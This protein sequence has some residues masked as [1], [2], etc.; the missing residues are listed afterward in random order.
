MI[1]LGL[2]LTVPNW[3]V[4]VHDRLF[5]MGVHSLLLLAAGVLLTGWL[6]FFIQ[7]LACHVRTGSAGPQYFS[8][9]HGFPDFPPRMDRL[10]RLQRHEQALLLWLPMGCFALLTAVGLGLQ[11]IPEV[12]TRGFGT[13]LVLAAQTRWLLGLLPLPDSHFLT[14]LGRLLGKENILVSWQRFYTRTLPL[15]WKMHE[16]LNRHQE[17]SMLLSSIYALV[18][19]VVFLFML[20]FSWTGG[21]AANQFAERHAAF[22]GPAAMFLYRFMQWSTLAIAVLLAL[23]WAK[24]PRGWMGVF[25]RKSPGMVLLAFI[26]LF[27]V[28]AIPFLF[29]P[30]SLHPRVLSFWCLVIPALQ[31]LIPEEGR[32]LRRRWKDMVLPVLIVCT[33]FFWSSQPEERIFPLSALALY[34]LDYIRRPAVLR[35]LLGS[36]RLRG[37]ALCFTLM[38]VFSLAGLGCS[39][40][41]VGLGVVVCI[42]LCAV[43][44][45][46]GIYMR[47]SVPS[48]FFLDPGTASRWIRENEILEAEGS[49][50]HYASVVL[51]KGVEVFF[52]KSVASNLVSKAFRLS[53]HAKVDSSS[54][55]YGKH[56]AG[57]LALKAG[58][59]RLHRVLA[60]T[61]GSW[62]TEINFNEVL[63]QPADQ[64]PWDKRGFLRAF[65]ENRPPL[66]REVDLRAVLKLV[67]NSL[68]FSSFDDTQQQRIARAMVP[69]SFAAGSMVFEQGDDGDRL[70]MIIRGSVQVNFLDQDGDRHPLVF[71]K[72]GDFFG[73]QALLKH[74]PRSASVRVLTESVLVSFSSRAF[75]ELTMA[76]PE[77]LGK[78]IRAVDDLW[79]IKTTPIF[80][81][82]R[83]DSLYPVL[84]AFQHEK[85]QAGQKV[86][87][88]GGKGDK[89]YIIKNGQATVL[90]KGKPIAR[91]ERGD[92]F[93]EI[94]LLRDI[95]RTASIVAETELECL[96]LSGKTFQGI[97]QA[98]P[99]L[100][101]R[102]KNESVHRLAEQV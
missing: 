75:A 8:L 52:G 30:G 22:S 5:S 76:N 32:D 40:A 68:L 90:K 57:I 37:S 11:F 91:L 78:L 87:S 18:C 39:Y 41:G 61:V 71:L 72:R 64:L 7:A 66:E 45:L 13:A 86:F 16:R 15:I 100:Q 26:G 81:S 85:T 38:A 50:F 43:M 4:M 95:P 60:H 28:G 73:E 42:Y 70:Y 98:N 96:V 12:W 93:G 20:R 89:F 58:E 31:F 80:Q 102:L 36:G 74:R 27:L 33:L 69:E 3:F 65:L 21:V 49:Q 14:G 88:E 56:T 46:M 53:G 25:L 23:R 82:F 97:L 10:H 35:I 62:L 51:E 47:Y 101:S 34:F 67:K 48:P 83:G 2:W 17:K 84:S 79:F 63:S 99:S 6:P 55:H 77:A 59:S 19:A 54:D 94:A 92:H 29:M 1:A 9:R 24:F 44:Q